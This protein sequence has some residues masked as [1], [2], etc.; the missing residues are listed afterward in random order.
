MSDVIEEPPLTPATRPPAPSLP[1]RLRAGWKRQ[2]PRL[3]L[4]LGLLLFLG[5]MAI[6][7][8]YIN[9][10]R[11]GIT[12]PTR[13]GL[14][15]TRAPLSVDH[16]LG[17]DA[18]GR[19]K[20]ALL[21][22][23]IRFSLQIGVV[24]ALVATAFA[25]VVSLFGG[26]L[27]GVVDDALGLLTMAILV[28]PALP[29]LMAVATFVDVGLWGISLALAFF[30][31]P[32]GARVI[33]AQVLSLKERPY[34][35]FARVSGF[36]PMRIMFTEILPSLVPFV[37]VGFSYSVIGGIMAETGLRVIGLGP[38][39][40]VSLGQLLN[41]AITGGALARGDYLDVALP[42]LFLVAVFAALNLIN[43]GLEE[44]FN[45]RLQG[46]TGG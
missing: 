46:V 4:G 38:G 30:M 19:D 8:P 27:G 22:I 16:P 18:L 11:L 35:E 13:M 28:A 39:D 14:F 40:V 24:V 43:V 7:A 26:Y 45:P 44:R 21:M 37:A 31:W 32:L 29:V 15:E 6:V 36:G 1:A 41:F 42:S 10:W 3:K 33:R 9:E 20:L 5:V 25:L 23:G 12:D 2:S 34:I 17:T